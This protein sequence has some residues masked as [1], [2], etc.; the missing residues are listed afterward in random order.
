[1]HVGETCVVCFECKKKKE[2]KNVNS[3]DDVWCQI[4]RQI[5]C[6]L[7]HRCRIQRNIEQDAQHPLRLGHCHRSVI[8]VTQG[9]R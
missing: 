1:M 7:K 6:K 9:Q 8:K 5:H 4:T 2:W 3:K